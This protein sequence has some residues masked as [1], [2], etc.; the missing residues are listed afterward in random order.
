MCCFFPFFFYAWGLP[1]GEHYSKRPNHGQERSWRAEVQSKKKYIQQLVYVP[2]PVL[3]RAQRMIPSG[4]STLPC[5]APEARWIPEHPS[6]WW[7]FFFPFVMK[8][9]DEGSEGCKHSGGAFAAVTNRGRS[10]ITAAGTMLMPCGLWRSAL[11][12]QLCIVF[13][14]SHARPSARF[15]S[16]SEPKAFSEGCTAFALLRT[17]HW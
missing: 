3:T 1:P 17:Q 4:C 9:G 2:V 15:N 10:S 13:A 12:H 7:T 8:I 6:G 16:S 14:Q 5:L 11:G